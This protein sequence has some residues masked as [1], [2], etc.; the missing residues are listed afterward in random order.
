MARRLSDAD[1]AAF[2]TD[3]FIAIENAIP[4][5]LAAEMRAILWPMTGCDP[6]DPTTWTRPVVRIGDLAGGPFAAAMDT[7][8]L[9]DAFDRLVG[10][11]RWL[12]RGSLGTFPIRFPSAED[13]GD[14][15]WHIDPSFGFEQPDF[16]AW[17]VNV[18]SR[19]RTLLMLVLISDVG[20]DDAPTRI[21]VGSHRDVARCLAPAGEAGL[22]LRELVEID[23]GGASRRDTTL[24]TGP[25]GTVY[26]CHP[27]LVH[28]AQPHRGARPRFL[29]QPALLPAAPLRLDRPAGEQSPVEAAIRRALE[30]ND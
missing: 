9:R 15:G 7:P 21:R 19:G 24:A 16:M 11:G 27:F 13:P 2:V 25:A 8:V 1:L 5:S 20:R 4:A 22:T 23:F 28:A 3:G 29:A 12:R 17:R 30:T 26:L 10:P 18:V 14:A 6:D